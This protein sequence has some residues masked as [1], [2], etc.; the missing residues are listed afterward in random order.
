MVVIQY[1]TCVMQCR[2]RG[3]SLEFPMPFKEHYESTLKQDI[4]QFTMS[5]E[6]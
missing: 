5:I 3:A 4:Q 1:D 6:R 2:I